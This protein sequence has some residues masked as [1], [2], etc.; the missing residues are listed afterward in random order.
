LC[1][2][3]DQSEREKARSYRAVLHYLTSDSEGDVSDLELSLPRLFENF[4]E[5]F[6]YPVVVFHDGLSVA[7]RKRIVGASRNKV[8]FAFVE[9]FVAVPGWISSRRK[10]QAKLKDVK[11]SLGYRGMCKF[12]TMT[13]FDQPV[14]AKMDYLMTL[15]TDGY[16]PD[17]VGFDP[18]RAMAEAKKVYTYSH[19]LDDQPAAV[20]YFWE[21]TAMYMRD[22]GVDWNQRPILQKNFVFENK[23]NMKLYMNDIEVMQIDWFRGPLYRDY[24]DYL[25]AQGGWWLYRWGDHAVRTM[26]VGMWL[27]ETRDLMHMTIPYAHQSYCRCAADHRICVP[28]AVLFPERANANPAVSEDNFQFL[29]VDPSVD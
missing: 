26:A 8:W 27:D 7:N 19:T 6:E 3:V 17:R 29:C 2:D 21:H 13:I 18:I 1:N 11:W 10:Y 14:L 15:D 28:R 4:N 22:R 5:E 16:L 20:Q 12:R 23:W 9:D 25:D 24:F